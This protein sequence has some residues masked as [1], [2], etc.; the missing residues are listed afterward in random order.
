[1]K[2][3]AALKWVN[4]LLAEQRGA[5]LREPEVVI[6]KGTWQG[7][8]YEKMADDSEYSLNY[9]M[10]DIA[11]KLW[12]QLS[13]IFEC[14]TGK[15]NF[16]V[17]LET[18]VQENSSAN[19]TIEAEPNNHF[20]DSISTK[21]IAKF[22]AQRENTVEEPRAEHPSV[23]D[24]TSSVLYG[25]ESELAQVKLWLEQGRANTFT[26]TS[27]DTQQ[28]VDGQIRLIGIWG[29]KGIG[30]SLLCE[31]AIAQMDVLFESVIWRTFKTD[32]SLDDFC[33][34][35]LNSLNL[36]AQPGQAAAKLLA[37]LEQRQILL[38][39]EDIE[40]IF[41]PGMLAGEYQRSHQNYSDFFQS[42][43]ATGHSCLIITGLE[44]PA[45]WVNQEGQNS[46]VRSLLLNGISATASMALLASE[47]L[48]TA[49]YWPELITRYQGH[50]LA[51]K[52]AAR[53]IREIFNRRV[54]AFLQQTSAPLYDAIQCLLPSFERL[55]D[56]E[57]NVLYWLASQE[58]PLS[59]VELQETLQ[60]SGGSTALISALDS[61]KQRA[62]LAIQTNTA[63]TNSNYP[64]FELPTLVKSCAIQQ[65][66]TKFSSG[67]TAGSGRIPISTQSSN[68]R[69][70]N[71]RA[72]DLLTLS[73][74]TTQPTCLSQWVAGCFGADW[75]SLNQLFES[76]SK[77]TPRSMVRLRNTYHLRDETFIKRC[78]S[79]SL[80]GDA[81]E[82]ENLLNAAQN[83][84]VQHSTVEESTAEVIMLVAVHPEET[85]TYAICVQVQPQKGEK[86]LPNAMSLRLLDGNQSVLAEI[87]SSKDDTFIQLPYFLG[88][89][90]ESFVIELLLNQVQHAEAF[91]V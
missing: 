38:A 66:L 53:V 59:L 31:T 4:A 21:F 45:N 28:P 76:T 87:Q 84:S 48:Q 14:P 73:S 25:Y 10:R 35:I 2:L 17:V 83:A 18:F 72:K 40:S 32:C 26:N 44:S 33:L 11:P 22:T 13:S 85:D 19:S 61:L 88:K 54:D 24:A 9:L 50:P 60:L 3:T 68:F 62:L 77:S 5:G 86:T 65:L 52:S 16:R 70:P 47:S 51:L 23:A 75:S 82:S 74:S 80:Q 30:K 91:L 15:T 55:S 81:N 49:E 63:Q 58:N 37:A 90:T 79:I 12:K 67:D 27:Q 78:K 7:C 41:Q 6:L 43:L 64:T 56:L 20:S 42:I 36:D 29:L 34:S 57:N 69:A 1:M 46:G 8:T 89:K 39:L 71:F